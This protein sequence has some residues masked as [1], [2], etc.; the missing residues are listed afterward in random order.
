M[1]V[2]SK[3]MNHSALLPR[4]AWNKDALTDP[5]FYLQ[6][7]EEAFR[8]IVGEYD[9]KP[10]KIGIFIPC[11][12]KKPYSA[13]PSHRLFRKVIDSTLEPG[14]YQI[15]IFGTCGAVP[16][17]LEK[18]Y[19]YA[20]YHYML[21][22]C[23]DIRIKNDFLEIETSRIA[24][25]LER[26]KNCYQKRI[27]YCIGIFREAM[28]KG[29]IRSGIPV[30]LLLPTNPTIERLRDI[31]CPFPD[32]SLSMEE[33]IEEFRSGLMTMKSALPDQ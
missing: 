3:F 5:P 22:N 11:A 28:I 12:V 18:M 20:H 8:Y 1:E 2:L 24:A 32:G 21:G 14:D 7:F 17:E 6:E 26:T 9:I 15:V 30:D 31:D 10:G 13:S 23:P 19:P 4:N 29:S 27:A 16:S 25:Y 33:Y